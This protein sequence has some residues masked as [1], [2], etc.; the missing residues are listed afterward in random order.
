MTHSSRL[1]IEIIEKLELFSMAKLDQVLTFIK[2]LDNDKE[3][4]NRILS[5]S[6]VW[7]DIEDDVMD[8]L[9]IH[10]HTNRAKDVRDF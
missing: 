8:D 6:G 4:P 1:K 10:L 9:T 2:R 5:Y 3:L 7:K